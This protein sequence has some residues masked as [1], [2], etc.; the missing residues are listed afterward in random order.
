MKDLSLLHDSY[1]TNLFDTV[2]EL[3][4]YFTIGMY[5]KVVR[6]VSDLECFCVHL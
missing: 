6:F 2:F 3:T 4:R 5:T 1:I